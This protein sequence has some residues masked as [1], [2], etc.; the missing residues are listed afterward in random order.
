MIQSTIYDQLPKNILVETTKNS[1]V[2]WRRGE[3]TKIKITYQVLY[4]STSGPRGLYYS[5]IPLRI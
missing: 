2:L 1:W 4:E 3:D 5:Y